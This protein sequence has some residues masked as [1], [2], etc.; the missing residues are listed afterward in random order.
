MFKEHKSMF[1][2]KETM[3]SDS[4]ISA[5]KLLTSVKIQKKS[6]FLKFKEFSL[7]FN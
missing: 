6:F 4:M 1:S 3:L 5:L 7:K 2:H